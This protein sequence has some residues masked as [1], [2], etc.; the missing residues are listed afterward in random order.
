MMIGVGLHNLKLQ[1]MSFY[2]AAK[3]AITNWEVLPLFLKH[4]LHIAHFAFKWRNHSYSWAAYN[5]EHCL[6]KYGKIDY[7]N[8]AF[9]LR[10]MA[11][12]LRESFV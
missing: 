3:L 2:T 11:D 10:P 4:D 6:A 5:H 9:I 8:C 12:S 7:R 1:Y